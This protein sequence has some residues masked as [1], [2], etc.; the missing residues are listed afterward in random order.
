MPT[1]TK[2]VEV[3]DARQFQGTLKSAK[4]LVGW[5]AANEGEASWQQTHQVKHDGNKV[6]SQVTQNVMS[7]YIDVV[8]GKR[9]IKN[10]V[11]ISEGSWILIKQ[12]GDFDVKTDDEM[13]AE[14]D[15]K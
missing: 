3:V 4:E 8:E 6:V 2:K 5:V 12:N 7:V 11:F 15:I 13:Q 14:Y 10:Q 9:E 1:F